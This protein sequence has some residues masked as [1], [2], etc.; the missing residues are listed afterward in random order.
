MKT[1]AYLRVSTAQQDLR[2]QRLAILDAL[3][4]SG[5]A[6]ELPKSLF[7]HRCVILSSCFAKNKNVT[8][9]TLYSDSL[10]RHWKSEKSRR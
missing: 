2:S 9:K 10:P 4:K 1:V 6:M 8:Q 5:V 3:A 7:H